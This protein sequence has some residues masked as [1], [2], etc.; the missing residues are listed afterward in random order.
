[1]SYSAGPAS[2]ISTGGGSHDAL[3]RPEHDLA[4]LGVDDDRLA[5]P[6]LLPQDA[7]RQGV[8]DVALDGTAQGTGAQRGVVAL[9][10]QVVLGRVGELEGEALAEELRLQ[11]PHHQ[12][13]DLDDLGP[14]QLVEHDG[15]VD[16]VQE[17]GAEV[18]LERLVH[19][20]L[21]LLVRHRLAGL[22]EADGG[23]AEVGRAQVGRHDDD[24]VL[25]VDRAPLGVGEAPVLQDLEQGVEDV[26][27]G[28]LDL[29]EE[30]DRERLA[31]DGLGEL[32]TLLVAHVAGG[33]AHQPGHGVLLHVLGHVE[34]DEVALVAEEELGQ[35]LGQLGLAHARGAQEDERAAGALGV[36][37]A[38]PGAADGLGDGLDGVLLADDPL[39]QL[40]LHPE[41]LG[42]LLL[43]E[44]VDGDARPHGQHL[45]DGLLVDLVE[46]VD[47]LGL[48]VGLLGDLAVEQG[49][50]LVAQLGRLLELLVLDR[51]FLLLADGGDLLLELLVVG[52]ASSSAA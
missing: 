43:G 21:H 49:L 26:G 18:L 19:L 10:G 3:D 20:L 45:G 50:L 14:G 28:L 51:R 32:A 6:E 42:R 13:D 8:L 16:P 22:L 4:V 38:G 48:P 31:A 2:A 36:L 29:V 1:M 17:L 12:V 15:V 37:E 40:L 27:V 30:H 34:L 7:L 24:G 47:A 35:R 41:Q 52:R 9:L 5:G 39:V 25:E 11:P 44:L 46:E 23:L 33:R